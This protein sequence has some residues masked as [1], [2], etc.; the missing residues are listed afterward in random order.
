MFYWREG[1]AT[2]TTLRDMCKP[3]S[4]STA[5]PTTDA[6][7]ASTTPTC[8]HTARPCEMCQRYHCA[9]TGGAT[10][11]TDLSPYWRARLDTA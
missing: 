1:S 11:F 2:L 10:Y 4:L 7:D 3:P 8:G 9:C 5:S 6:G